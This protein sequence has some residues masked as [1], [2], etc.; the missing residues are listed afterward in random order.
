MAE[1]GVAPGY[2]AEAID[3]RYTCAEAIVM[4]KP[5]RIMCSTGV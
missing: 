3:T 2:C 4:V 1:V 5:L